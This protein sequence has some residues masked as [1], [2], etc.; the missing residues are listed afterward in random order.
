M[1]IYKDLLSGVHL[2]PIFCLQWTPPCSV[3][4][5]STSVCA[6]DEVLSDSYDITE[7][8]DGFFYQVEGKVGLR[9]CRLHKRCKA[10]VR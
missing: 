9:E 8:E 3:G 5:G 2:P 10:H 4:S 7:V 1:L 6:G